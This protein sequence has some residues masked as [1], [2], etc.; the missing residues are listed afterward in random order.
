MIRH[1]PVTITSVDPA[2][3]SEGTI[4]TLKG[5]GF[6]KHIRNNCVVVGGM[7]ACA[8]PE[9]DDSDTELKIRI[10]PVAEITQGDIL[11]WPGIGLDLHTEE[12]EFGKSRLTFSETAIF[13]NG[14]PQ[15]SAGIQ[16]K[17]T[18]ESPNTFSGRYQ[19]ALAGLELGAL[20]GGVMRVSLPGGCGIS[21]YK[22]VDACI[23]LKEP[24]LAIDFSA[25]I[26]SPDDEECLRAVSKTIET[27]A[28]LVGERVFSTV[29]LDAKSGALELF[30][31]KPYLQRGM[32]CLRFS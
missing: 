15:T 13:R 30:V 23:V 4:V 7:G 29:T 14:A 22:S 1:T 9:T 5:T 18:K 20:E 8:R 24:T 26:S 10:G 25:N 2:E 27:N 6:A 21:R 12:I 31:T 16:F 32:I 17:L 28:A 19:D 3:G 11:I